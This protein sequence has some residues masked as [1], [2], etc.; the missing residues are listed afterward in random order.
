[1]AR[2]TLAQLTALAAVFFSVILAI[3][4]LKLDANIA[5]NRSKIKDML[6]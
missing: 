3:S 6:G 2:A 5:L 4:L 1:M